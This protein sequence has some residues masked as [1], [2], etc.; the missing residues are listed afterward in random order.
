[1][2]NK[3]T[4][5]NAVGSTKFPDGKPEKQQPK[6]RQD[7]PIDLD[8]DEYTARRDFTKFLMLTSLAFVVGQF[9]IGVQSLFRRNRGQPS[10]QRIARVDELAVGQALS[11]HYPTAND[12]CVLIRTGAG[13]NAGDFRAYGSQCTHLMCAVCP[14]PE[15]NRLHCPCHRGYFDLSTGR[16]TAGPPRRPLPLV[17]LRVENGTIYATAVE[18]R[19]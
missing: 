4:E 10:Q 11:F 12:P 8:N 6:W 14:E 15:E 1:M 13:Q 19:T 2:N 3:S 7:F 16:P 9:W 5:S 17:S 18:L